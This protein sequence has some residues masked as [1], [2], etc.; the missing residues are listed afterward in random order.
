MSKRKKDQQITALAE[1]EFDPMPGLLAWEIT[2][3]ASWRESSEALR[4]A[5]VLARHLCA[6][7][8]DALRSATAALWEQQG[9]E[10]YS[11]MMDCLIENAKRC[12]ALAELLDYAT[13]RGLAAL[14]AYTEARP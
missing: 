9:Q 12:K 13:A 10:A 2:D 7:D 6:K 4:V 11:Q 14:A 1:V 3:H 8:R 5:V